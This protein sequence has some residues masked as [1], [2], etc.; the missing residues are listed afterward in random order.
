MFTRLNTEVLIVGSGISGLL[1]AI[2]LAKSHKVL[3]LS[4]S[5]TSDCSTSWAQGGIATAINDQDDVK[6]HAEDTILNGHYIC[7]NDSVLKIIKQGKD[8]IDLLIK[9]GVEF[10]KNGEKLKQT[11]EGGHSKRRIAYHNDNTGEEIHTSL[12]KKAK[13]NK[14]ITIKENIMAIDLIGDKDKH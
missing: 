8:S 14:N 3:I 6:K 12:L 2:E 5:H 9:Y 4:K 1:C 13:S 11:L 7:D 10:N